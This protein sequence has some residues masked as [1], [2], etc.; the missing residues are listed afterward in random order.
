MLTSINTFNVSFL[1]R[2]EGMQLPPAASWQLLCLR[3]ALGTSSRRTM[4]LKLCCCAF[5]IWLW[6][7]PSTRVSR[8]WMASEPQPKAVLCLRV[9]H[10]RHKENKWG[11]PPALTKEQVL[12]GRERIISP[13]QRTRWELWLRSAMKK[14]TFC[15]FSVI[16]F[17]SLTTV[18]PAWGFSTP[19]KHT[20]LLSASAFHS[21]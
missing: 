20:G 18:C 6:S 2:V 7:A 17:P 13:K 15:G 16:L 9:L 14:N 19:Y 5:L 10:S 3:G 11:S 8:P 12:E 21:L 4:W 1:K